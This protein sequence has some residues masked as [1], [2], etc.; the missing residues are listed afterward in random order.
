VE[1]HVRLLHEHRYDPPH[2]VEVEHEGQWCP[3]FQLR[4][5]LCDDDRGWM[6]QVEYTAQHDCG[7]G[8]HLASVPPER[9]RIAD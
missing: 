1:V 7:Y 4:W 5:M 8:K 2:P 6:A 9:I 3:G